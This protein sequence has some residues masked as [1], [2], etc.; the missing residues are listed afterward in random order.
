MIKQEVELREQVVVE[1]TRD[2]EKKGEENE[3]DEEEEQKRKRNK[4]MQRLLQLIMIL[5]K[6]KKKRGNIKN[7]QLGD[8][9]EGTEKRKG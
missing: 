2:I 1:R 7:E 4:R 5:R 8:K 6:R 3:V 9:K